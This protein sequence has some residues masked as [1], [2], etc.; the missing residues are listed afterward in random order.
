MN[1]PT[2]FLEA[3]IPPYSQKKTV[4]RL[5]QNRQ[6]YAGYVYHMTIFSRNGDNLS[7]MI[8]PM[9]RFGYFQEETATMDHVH[10]HLITNADMPFSGSREEL[11]HEFILLHPMKSH[12]K[13]HQEGVT[14]IESENGIATLSTRDEDVSSVDA[15]F[16]CEKSSTVGE[17]DET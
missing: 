14:H 11:S 2:P 6:W 12:S 5:F 8:G 10:K 16:E 15:L 17:E 4:I 3:D 13:P 1:A 9:I 7:L